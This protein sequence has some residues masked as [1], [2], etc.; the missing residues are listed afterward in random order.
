[1]EDEEHNVLSLRKNRHNAFALRQPNA[2]LNLGASGK[3]GSGLHGSVRLGSGLHGSMIHKSGRHAS[4][5]HGSMLQK[6]GANKS[7]KAS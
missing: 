5:L 6:S 7:Q 2:E 4:G 1:M 3:Y